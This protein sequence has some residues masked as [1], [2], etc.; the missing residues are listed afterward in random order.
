MLKG[1]KTYLII[2]FNQELNI[3]DFYLKN[4]M[5]LV[6]KSKRY[7]NYKLYIRKE[8]GC[9]GNSIKNMTK[10]HIFPSSIYLDHYNFPTKDSYR[11]VKKIDIKNYSNV[12]KTVINEYAK[13]VPQHE[14]SAFKEYIEKWGLNPKSYQQVLCHPVFWGFTLVKE[15]ENTANLINRNNNT[16]D[17]YTK[18]IN[19]LSKNEVEIIK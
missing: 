8:F 7:K 4:A 11:R 17:N 5:V 3:C 14:M 12:I 16:K 10:N 6:A 15:D 13:I 9:S 2:P 18:I 19:E 1:K